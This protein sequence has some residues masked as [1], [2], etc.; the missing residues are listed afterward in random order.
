MDIPL[1]KSNLLRVIN[2]VSPRYFCSTSELL[3]NCN[4]NTSTVGMDTSAEN[5]YVLAVSVFGV[6]SIS[7][8]T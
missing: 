1:S 3:E 7:F 5:E 6:L 8:L 2:F 4:G